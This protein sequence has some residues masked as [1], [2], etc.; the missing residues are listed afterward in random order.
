MTVPISIFFINIQHFSPVFNNCSWII[1]LIGIV[2]LLSLFLNF[3]FK[4]S[5]NSKTRYKISSKFEAFYNGT[6]TNNKDFIKFITAEFVFLIICCWFVD[7]FYYTCWNTNHIE[8]KPL[9]LP[10]YFLSI[11]N[12]N[13]V[14]PSAVS[15]FPLALCFSPA[16]N[17]RIRSFGY[18]YWLAFIPYFNVILLLEGLLPN[19]FL[20]RMKLLRVNNVNVNNSNSLYIDIITDISPVIYRNPL[21]SIYNLRSILA[22]AFIP[23]YALLKLFDQRTKPGERFL[24]YCILGLRNC[25]ALLLLLYLDFDIIQKLPEIISVL[26]FI[27]EV[28]LIIL[29]YGLCLREG[30]LLKKRIIKVMQSNPN[31]SINQIADY[32]A[33]SAIDVEKVVNK[34]L[35]KGQIE[36]EVINGHIKWVVKEKSGTNKS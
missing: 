7:L 29:T 24:I 18:S 12:L 2:V 34:L 11:F 22:I 33:F 35:K 3:F 4:P 19:S 15:I 9:K 16:L 10:L 8:W 17:A 27:W 13:I 5:S 30:Y 36:R 32:I 14:V 20:Q 25:I 6:I 31:F 28:A 26:L 1:N 23:F 21:K